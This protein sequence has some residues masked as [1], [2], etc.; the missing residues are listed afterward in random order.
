MYLDQKGWVST[1]IGNKLDQPRLANSVPSSERSFSPKLVAYQP[2]LGVPGRG[3][4]EVPEAVDACE[5]GGVMDGAGGD[6][7]LSHPRMPGLRGHV[8][9]PTR[10]RAWAHSAR[11]GR[12]EVWRSDVRIRV[13][14]PMP[15]GS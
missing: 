11:D 14:C 3:A 6:L 2:I 9:P 5:A 13:I 15:A 12:P 7:F 4:G 1:G 8:L 10:L